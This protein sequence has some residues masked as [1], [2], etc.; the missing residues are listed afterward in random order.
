MLRKYL[1]MTGVAMMTL[2]TSCDKDEPTPEPPAPP[3][4]PLTQLPK[5]LPQAE[6]TVLIYAVASNSLSSYLD[7][8]LAEI[9]NGASEVDLSK[10]RLLVYSVQTDYLNGGR[11]TP[12]LYYLVKT[13]F[14]YDYK[15]LKEYDKTIASTEVSRIKEV[16][17]DA[18]YVSPS[19]EYN[20]IFWSHS[21]A[22]RPAPTWTDNK[23]R[24]FGQDT[25][26][27]GS[28]YCEI[29][30][31]ASA[32]P[33]G[34]LNYVWFDS[35][36]MSNIESMYEFR[37]K[38][39]YFIGSATEVNGNGMPYD[40]TL[41][42]LMAG[43]VVKA[44]KIETDYYINVRRPVTMCVVDMRNFQPLVDATRELYTDF[45]PLKNP[46]EIQRYQRRM[47]TVLCDFRHFSQQEAEQT[48]KDYTNFYTALD[49]FILYSGHSNYDF[50]NRPIR[51]EHYSGISCHLFDE[52]DNLENRMYR[53]LGWYKEVYPQ[54]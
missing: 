43:D 1:I 46:D 34:M 22:W 19:G 26:T 24:S 14:G 40:R 6:K 2:F 33:D 54:K 9:K 11:T 13:S 16:I 15:L 45:Q 31:L 12:K 18:T 21:D 8:D 30:D 37:N 10:N 7:S 28:S 23:Q 32:I 36:Y 39:R 29:A 17:D 41:K 50:A 4:P 27:E 52:S 20:M 38:C 53:M 42:Y 51:S 44:A 48:G 3:T 5:P 35:C 47:N 49:N 25:G